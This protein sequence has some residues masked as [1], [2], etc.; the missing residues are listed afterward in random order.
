MAVSSFLNKILETEEFASNKSFSKEYV[1]KDS[2]NKRP[3]TVTC[4]NSDFSFGGEFPNEFYFDS[5]R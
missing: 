3:T 2:Y 1:H 4:S 5:F